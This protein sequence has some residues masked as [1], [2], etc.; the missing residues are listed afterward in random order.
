MSK[1]MRAPGC[2]SQEKPWFAYCPDNGFEFFKTKA[3][4][5]ESAELLIES[6]L[7]DTWADE[8]E[9]VF[10]GQAVMISTQVDRKD[11]PEDL[12][13]EDCDGEGEYWPMDAEFKCN[14]KLMPVG[15]SAP[16]LLDALKDIV[17][18]CEII[19]LQPELEQEIRNA[20][21][22]IAKAE[23]GAS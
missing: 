22:S 13:E 21:A 9:H 6:W 1:V 11:R 7:D 5:E 18:S 10:V 15:D 16:D 2:V 17:S 14:Y 19:G 20:K 4:A 12:D 8:V 3:E 23:G